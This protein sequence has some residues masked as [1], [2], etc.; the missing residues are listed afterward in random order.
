[1]LKLFSAIVS[2]PFLATS[3]VAEED[4]TGFYAGA[5]AGV[6]R[7]EILT[8]D[9]SGFGY[10]VFAGY[11]Y[12]FGQF[13][14]GGEID[15]TTAEYTLNSV[16]DDVSNTRLKIRGGYDLG[17]TLVYAVAGGV[18]ANGG[19]INDNGFTLGLGADF[20]LTENFII[21][22]EYKHDFIDVDALGVDVD[23]D[24]DTFLLRASYKF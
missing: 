6:S 4:W 22:A 19:G 13:V 23:L 20:K 14:L 3:V 9:D 16:T 17:R 8:S 11:N 1:M 10:G 5:Q 7:L 2:L 24:F 18:R 15:F 21:G 12:D